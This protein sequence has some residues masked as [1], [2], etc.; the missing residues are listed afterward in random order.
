[1]TLYTARQHLKFAASQLFDLVAD[2]EGYPQFLPWVAE[3][4]IRRREDRKVFVDMT[5]RLG[6]LRTRFSSVGILDRP[7]RIDV[8]SSDAPFERF[9]QRW[10]F[11]PTA[12]GGT[13]VE[14]QVD[15][16]LR[17][18]TL[19]MLMNMSFAERAEATVTAFKRRA[20]RL[21]GGHP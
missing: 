17:S 14:Y 20:Q 4:R 1:M 6:P 15:C 19:H 21:Y 11:T 7:Q 10:T 3:S 18:R 13:D 2:V 9:T 8:S 12:D 5:I 16:R